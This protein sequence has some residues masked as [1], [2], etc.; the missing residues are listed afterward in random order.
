M[1]FFIHMRIQQSIFTLTVLCIAALLTGCN[2]DI[3][4]KPLKVKA[5]TETLSP[6][7]P[8][9]FIRVSG[10][11]WKVS[12]IW[13]ESDDYVYRG[14]PDGNSYTFKSPFAEINGHCTDDGIVVNL[15][16]YLGSSVATVGM[17]VTDGYDS[18]DVSL[19]VEPTREYSIEILGVD[20]TLDSWWGYP[21]EAVTSKVVSFRFP[22][23]LTES[24][25]FTFDKPQTMP[26]R[27]FFEPMYSDNVFAQQVVSCGLTVPIPTPVQSGFRWELTGEEVPLVSSAQQ[28]D[29]TV[30]PP[31]PGAVSLPA[32]IPLSVALLCD[33][34][35]VGFDCT[36][37]AVNPI[38]E[39]PEEVQCRLHLLVP[40]KFKSE[41]A[42]L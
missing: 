2:D 25:Q 1:F 11:D 22:Q 26:V 37:T 33:Y 13:Y 8:T 15:V 16:N 40:V 41:V 24:R 10:D 36:V 29:S 39:Q 3:F 9:A 23:G 6:D 30:M 34:E 14:V 20:Y 31:M 12:E 4:I 19:K 27:Y 17:T 21:D 35:S 5:D 18:V 28:Y 42:E 38:T 32:G 7:S